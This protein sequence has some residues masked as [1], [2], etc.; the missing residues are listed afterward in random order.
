MS[1]LKNRNSP[2]VTDV[3]QGRYRPGAVTHPG[4]GCRQKLCLVPSRQPE[5]LSYFF[6]ASLDDG[7]ILV[8][9]VS[10]YCR[11]LELLLSKLCNNAK[12]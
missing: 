12:T 2:S 8:Y 6:V 1:P 3:P 9:L 4:D 5:S 11:E 10:P 7:G